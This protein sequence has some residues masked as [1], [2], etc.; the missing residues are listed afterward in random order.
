MNG[1]KPTVYRV[2]GELG[3]L[4]F[5]HWPGVDGRDAMAPQPGKSIHKTKGFNEVALFMAACWGSYRKAAEG[6]CRLVHQAGALCGPT[7]QD[8]VERASTRYSAGLDKKAAGALAAN[9]FDPSGGPLAPVPPA[10]IVAMGG[11]PVSAAFE[12]MSNDAPP[13]VRPHLSADGA[14]ESPADTVNVSIDDICTKEQK[15]SR[16]RP[17][18]P[19]ADKTPAGKGKPARAPKNAPP[20]ADGGGKPKRKLPPRKQHYQTVVHLE[21]KA[22][23]YVLNGKKL[24]VLYAIIVA[25]L[26]S[27]GHLS[28][29]WVFFVDGQQTLHAGILSHFHWKDKLRIILDHYHLQKKCRHQFHMALHNNEQR[30]GVMAMTATYLWYGLTAQ[31]IQHLRDVDGA[32][33]KNQKELDILIGYLER[34]SA[35]IPC[36]EMRK[37]L[38]LRNSS[39]IVEKAND[40]LVARRQKHNGMSWSS[41]GSIAL[42]QLTA[43][44]V[45]NGVEAWLSKKEIPFTWVPAKAA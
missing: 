29:N 12:G 18:A 24:E 37:R 17:G 20:A 27:N 38:G 43:I 15:R 45:N 9:G 6:Y 25:F 42:A 5:D 39:N 32:L 2:L 1:G 41:E 40:T 30:E 28:D 35:Y 44:R 3:A 33:V 26:A 31:A 22:G 10:A 4:K 8:M 36:Y 19:A 13:S 14:Y 7:L 23:K 11:A 34:N 16:R 21:G